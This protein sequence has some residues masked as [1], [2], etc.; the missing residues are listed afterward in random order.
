[1]M[2]LMIQNFWD[3]TVSFGWVVSEILKENSAFISKGHAVQ[4]D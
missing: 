4:E 2:L 1:M 3:N